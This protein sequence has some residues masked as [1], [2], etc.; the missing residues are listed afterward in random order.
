MCSLV[1]LFIWSRVQSPLKAVLIWLSFREHKLPFSLHQVTDLSLS[2][3][4]VG[5]FCLL[6]W[7]EILLL[8]PCSCFLAPS[9]VIE[10]SVRVSVG[11]GSAAQRAI[12]L[13][14][15]TYPQT[16]IVST[17]RCDACENDG[18]LFVVF[19][20]LCW[21]LLCISNPLGFGVMNCPTT[22]LTANGLPA[23]LTITGQYFGFSPMQGPF[24]ICPYDC[25]SFRIL[26]VNFSFLL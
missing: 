23:V 14:N 19:V 1:W 5:Y 25:D 13:A 10:Y 12:S 4:F 21:L 6:W 22:G 3:S 16:P 24:L 20:L 15:Y 9:K 26:L 2:L 7:Y 17:V 18:W 11:C 8:L